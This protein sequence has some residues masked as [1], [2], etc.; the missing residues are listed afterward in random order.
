MKKENNAAVI[1]N[2]SSNLLGFCLVVITS[3]HFAHFTE[4]HLVDELT[5]VIGILLM[6]S[7]LFSFLSLRSEDPERARR[8][9]N[10]ADVFFFFSLL[11]ILLV[12]LMITVHFI[13]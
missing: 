12:M 5:L 8:F 6:V 13:E 11:G 10:R 9:E 7:C 3:L 4:G 2:T 1:L